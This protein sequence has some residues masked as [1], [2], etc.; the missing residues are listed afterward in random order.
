MLDGEDVEINYRWY[1][2]DSNRWYAHSVNVT[3]FIEYKSEQ[4]IDMSQS[5]VITLT[6]QANRLRD[7]LRKVKEERPELVGRL[8]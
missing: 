2:A 3:G 1:N 5:T 8:P 6:Q 7:E 4:R